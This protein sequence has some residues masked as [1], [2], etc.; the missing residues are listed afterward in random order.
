[1]YLFSTHFCFSLHPQISFSLGN[2]IGLVSLIFIAS[3]FH[4]L[5]SREQNQTTVH[6]KHC[7]KFLKPDSKQPHTKKEVFYFLQTLYI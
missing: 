7:K 4:L 5:H 1:M 3:P 2:E 6:W